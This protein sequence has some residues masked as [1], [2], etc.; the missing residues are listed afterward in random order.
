VIIPQIW[1][2]ALVKV[3]QRDIAANEFF[4]EMMAERERLHKARMAVD[5]DYAREYEEFEREWA[6]IGEDE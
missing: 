2:D 4:T 5:A 3:C 6:A 1:Q